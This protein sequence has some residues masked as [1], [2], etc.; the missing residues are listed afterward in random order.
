VPRII[1]GR[2]TQIP[3]V[4]EIILVH[5]NLGYV[6]VRANTGRPI[7]ALA[8]RAGDAAALLKALANEQRLVIL[9]HLMSAGELS[10]GALCQRVRLSQSAL[11]QHLA[12]LREQALVTFRREAQSVFYRVCDPRAE[13]LLALLC[14]QICRTP[15]PV[16]ERYGCKSTRE[17]ANP[18]KNRRA[19]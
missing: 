14:E 16:K 10:V 13:Q 2:D 6:D 18:T 5:A 17:S 19:G 7:A 11:S 15:A 12:R 4:L 3:E 9:C 1:G 8:P